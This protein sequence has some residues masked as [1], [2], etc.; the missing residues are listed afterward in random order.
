MKCS[1]FPSLSTNPR[2]NYTNAKYAP[3]SCLCQIWT[4][5]QAAPELF[6]CIDIVVTSPGCFL[7]FAGFPS[8]FVLMDIFKCHILFIDLFFF[9]PWMDS[10]ELCWKNGSS[11]YERRPIHLHRFSFNPWSYSALPCY[12]LFWVWVF[13]FQKHFGL[14][15]IKDSILYLSFQHPALCIVKCSKN[16]LP[17]Q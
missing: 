11:S 10:I 3:T 9:F 1:R 13:S 14:V 5:H 8:S 7:D 16:M 15:L 4:I 17:I 6:L 12:L 2:H